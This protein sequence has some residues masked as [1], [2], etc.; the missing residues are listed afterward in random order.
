[1]NWK[2][3]LILGTSFGLLLA[4]NATGQDN[5]FSASASGLS[6]SELYDSLPVVSSVSRISQATNKAPA[7]VTIIDRDLIRASG[8]QNWVDIF[9]LVPGF[10]VYSINANRPGIDYHGIGTEFPRQLEVTVDGRSVYQPLFST[11]EW[12]VL[13]VAIED[14]DYIEVVR[15]SNAAS[16][17]SNA[18]KGAINIVTQKPHLDTSTQLRLTAGS[19]DTQRVSLSQNGYVGA[20][21]YQVNL[22]FEHNDGFPSLSGQPEPRDNGE[23]ADGR[24]LSTADFRGFYA[25]DLQNTFDFNLGISH[26]NTGWGD[27]DHPSEYTV[28][29]F[30]SNYQVLRW[31]RLN[32]AGNEFNLQFYHNGFEAEN[33]VPILL[34]DLLSGLLETEIPPALVPAVLASVCSPDDASNCIPPLEDQYYQLGF[35][36]IKAH[37]YDL[38][39]EHKLQPFTSIRLTWGLGMRNESLRTEHL[40]DS[41]SKFTSDSQRFFTSMEWSLNRQLTLNLGGML[42]HSDQID[43]LNS[44]RVALNFHPSTNHGLRFSYANGE[45]A[46]S[47]LETNERNLSRFENGVWEVIRVAQPDFTEER[48]E[49]FELA[50]MANFDQLSFDIKY[51]EEYLDEVVT[52]RS[53]HPEMILPILPDDYFLVPGLDRV[54]TTGNYLDLDISGVE[55]QLRYLFENNAMM[56]F[57]YTYLDIEGEMFEP[58]RGPDDLRP[59]QDRMP[60][61]TV[62]LLGQLNFTN[63][64]SGSLWIYHMNEVNWDDGNFIDEFTRVDAQI[65]Y[66]FVDNNLYQGS[67]S[68]IGQNLGEDYSDYSTNN[69]FDTRLYLKLEMEFH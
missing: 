66:Q 39:F 14:I 24:D 28:A 15:G 31:N 2:T 67:V 6:E 58:F 19:R 69:V 50:Y 38:E 45:R 11:V 51:F 22:G 3:I 25:P 12:S 63:D 61:H 42:E 43:T 68:L 59:Y 23:L 34:S 37:R 21:D 65:R 8:A 44:T 27:G 9:R 55:M 13:N 60:R 57:H 32:D 62:S 20:L 16:Q 56:A 33:D 41:H 17:G 30:D 1:M 26:N 46:P 52:D 53:E 35:G 54:K 29:D 49:S 18:F 40:L 47:V 48:I 64:I 7:S 10:Q 5:E 36:N 4:E